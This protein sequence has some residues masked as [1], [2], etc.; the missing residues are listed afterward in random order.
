M[1]PIPQFI[2]RSR[3]FGRPARRI[4][5][6]LTALCGPDRRG[7]H[8]VTPAS[9]AVGRLVGAGSDR[10]LDVVGGN[11]A[12]GTAYRSGTA[13]ARPARPGTLN[14]AG[15]SAR[16]QRHPVPGRLRRGH[17]AGYPADHLD[18]QRAGQPA[19]HA[20]A[21]RQH[22]RCRL[23]VCVST[24]PAR[25]P[26]T[27]PRWPCGPA[28]ARPTSAG[29]RAVART[30]PPRPR[31]QPTAGHLQRR[32]RSIRRPP[33]AA[34]RLLCYLYSQ[35]G[36]HILS[37]QQESTWVSG[38]DYEMNYIQS[39]TGKLP[40]DPRPGHGRLA[41]P[42]AAGRLAWWNAGGIPMVGYHMGAPEPDRRTAT[43]GRC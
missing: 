43:T 15:E 9:A 3:S 24:S 10:C 20:S 13:T 18:L 22:H 19:L 5:A 7:R 40:G 1:P 27:A 25:G 17:R 4:L 37:G 21:R 41:R 32:S 28:T 26:P 39:N 14:A 31:Q 35:Y 36:N 6:T 33:P 2:D 38:P 23:A 29:P 16:V 8:R 34:R 30:R 12:A 42:S 11:S